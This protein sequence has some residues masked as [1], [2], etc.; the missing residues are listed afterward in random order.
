VTLDAVAN[1]GLQIAR[2]LI[3]SELGGTFSANSTPS[4]TSVRLAIPL[5]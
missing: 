3:E 2:S 5:R 1:L 4:G